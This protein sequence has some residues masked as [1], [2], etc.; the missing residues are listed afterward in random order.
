MESGGGIGGAG[1][2]VRLLKD[3]KTYKKLKRDPTLNYQDKFKEAL[4]DLKVRGVIPDKMHSDLFPTTDQPPRFYGVPKVH[5][6][7]MPLQP[8]VSSI[9]TILY[10]V[11]KYLAKVLSSLEGTTEHH[12]KKSKTL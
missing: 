10:G 7:T 8:I 1:D 12:I 2:V 4:W 9:G 6:A 3:E 5:K 11:A